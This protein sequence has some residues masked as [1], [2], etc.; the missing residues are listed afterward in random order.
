VVAGFRK[1]QDF[2]L[3]GVSVTP[4]FQG[5]GRRKGDKGFE[6]PMRQQGELYDGRKSGPDLLCKPDPQ[7]DE[8][9]CQVRSE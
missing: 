9:Q 2:G 1:I 5:P 7:D 4:G 6:R 8:R 3:Q